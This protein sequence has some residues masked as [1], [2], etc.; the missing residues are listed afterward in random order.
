VSANRTGH[1]TRGVKGP[2][3]SRRESQC[4]HCGECFHAPAAA[5]GEGLGSLIER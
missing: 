5:A 2:A 4:G 1:W 3:G